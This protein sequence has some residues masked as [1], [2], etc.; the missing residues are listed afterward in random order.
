M[1]FIVNEHSL[2]ELTKTMFE[3]RQN[4]LIDIITLFIEYLNQLDEFYI[5]MNTIDELCYVVEPSIITTKS[6]Y[7][8]FK[9]SNF[10]YNL[11][12]LTNFNTIFICFRRKNIYKNNS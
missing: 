9:L 10:C 11:F 4:N 12:K 7:R 8:I 3:H 6:T 2:P 1:I 5:N